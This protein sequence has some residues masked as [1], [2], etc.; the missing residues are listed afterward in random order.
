MLRLSVS[1]TWS[2]EDEN[3]TPERV[4]FVAKKI[5]RVPWSSVLLVNS[6]KR[7]N[8]A[9]A[10]RQ[11]VAKFKSSRRVAVI[12]KDCNGSVARPADSF[13]MVSREIGSLARTLVIGLSL[14]ATSMRRRTCLLSKSLSSSCQYCKLGG[15]LG[16]R[17]RYRA[18]RPF[19]LN[20]QGIVKLARRSTTVL[21]LA[22]PRNFA[23]DSAF[24]NCVEPSGRRNAC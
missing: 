9:N 8:P 19:G 13:V 4:S 6:P 5:G 3:L 10:T 22:K 18:R 15:R 12:S 14:L 7:R 1:C 21:R 2:N 24:R 17:V 11:A 20:S 16:R 23:A